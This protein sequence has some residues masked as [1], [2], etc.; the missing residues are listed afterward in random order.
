MIVR[1]DFF[2]LQLDGTNSFSKK[3]NCVHNCY[4]CF[5]ATIPIANFLLIV[6]DAFSKARDI[7]NVIFIL[8]CVT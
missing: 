1:V 3:T 5:V 4:A 7:V 6:L 8:I 2:G